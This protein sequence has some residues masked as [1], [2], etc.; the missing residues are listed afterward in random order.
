MVNVWLMYGYYI[1]T[2]MVNNDLVGG[3]EQNPSEKWWS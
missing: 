2:N 3:F 1:V